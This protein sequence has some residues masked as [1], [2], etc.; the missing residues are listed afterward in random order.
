MSAFVAMGAGVARIMPPITTAAILAKRNEWSCARSTP[1][2]DPS[3]RPR[4]LPT[5][6]AA[7]FAAAQYGGVA[8]IDCAIDFA[9]SKAQLRAYRPGCAPSQRLEQLGICF[10]LPTTMKKLL[11][12]R[13]TFARRRCMECRTT[14]AFDRWPW[15]G[16]ILVTTHG[17]C[18]NCLQ[19]AQSSPTR[20][21]PRYLLPDR[22]VV[23]DLLN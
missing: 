15:N 6:E 18:A 20:R 12:M 10:A 11:P 22:K 4:G 1:I 17:L 3:R 2:L 8:G 13:V 21:V 23:S 16:R 19:R 5:F 9:G 7:E 14:T